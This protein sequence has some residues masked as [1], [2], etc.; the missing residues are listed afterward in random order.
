[1]LESRGNLA[2]VKD[3]ESTLHFGQLANSGKL[4]SVSFS[5]HNDKGFDTEFHTYGLVW[6]HDG[7]KFLLDGTEIGSVPA[8]DGY[9]YQGGFEGENAWKTGTKMA[10][11]DQ[12]V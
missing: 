10:P 7:I 11:F 4:K 8:Q 2:F 6:N 5:E 12:E 9:W 3:M 1:M